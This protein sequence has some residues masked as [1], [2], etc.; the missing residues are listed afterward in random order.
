MECGEFEFEIELDPQAL[1]RQPVISLTCPK[2]GS[3]TALQKRDGGG[4]EIG[5]DKHL[6][7]K[8]AGGS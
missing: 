3:S 5:L 4:V 8:R 1:Q 6:K 2:C 7:A